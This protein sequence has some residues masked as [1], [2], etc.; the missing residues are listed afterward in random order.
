MIFG[1]K[2]IMSPE[3]ERQVLNAVTQYTKSADWKK[4]GLH[5]LRKQG[6][7]ILLQGPPGTGK[8]SIAEYLALKIRKKGL[9]SMSFADFGSHVPGENSRQIRKFFK[10]A[11]ANGYMT[12]FLD[13]CEAVL[14]DRSNIVGSN[15]WMLEVID[16]L[17]AQISKYPGLIILA[18]NRP[19]I[20]DYALYRRLI[21][22][23]EVLRPAAPERVRL[24]VDKI[25][26]QHPLKLQPNQLEEIATL[27]LTGAEIE[28]TIII[29]SSDCLR[30]NHKPNFVG[31]MKVATTFVQK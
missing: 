19:Q 1:K 30:N 3:L 14:W 10:E 9:K 7:A 31:L 28:N 22:N 16:E 17:L 20:L 8:T 15:T 29:Y 2:P 21:A 27:Q 26:E 25:P 5:N 12:I 13:E 11:T 4:W 23:I 6:A 24:W 18:T